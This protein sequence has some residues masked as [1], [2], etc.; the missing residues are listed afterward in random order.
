MPAWSSLFTL[1][2]ASAPQVLASCAYGT[3]L[4]PRAEAGAFEEPKF[5]YNGIKG[6]VNWYSLDAANAVCATGKNQS[7]INM[8]KGSF[9]LIPAS[10]LT[11]DIPDFTEGAEFE[12][13]GTTVEIIAEEAGGGSLELGETSYELKQFHFHLPSEHLDNGTSMAMEMHMVWQSA[14]EDIAVIGVYID[15]DD[16]ATAAASASAKIHHARGNKGK[17]E[18]RS[19]LEPR[20][21]AATPSTVLETVLG[22]VDKIAT[23]GATTHTEPLAMS[24]IVKLLTSGSFQSYAGSLTTPPCSEGVKWLVSNK[25]VS[26]ST[27]TYLKARS[28]IGFNARY[29]QNA[30]GEENLLQLAADAEDAHEGDD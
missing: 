10:E 23:P 7:P 21:S 29:P 8:A 30:P 14:E 9:N 18:K 5:G 3:H 16:G 27:S 17:M 28:V 19:A 12:N 26:I 22:S 24:E 15:L 6:P 13:L 20:Q 11:L 1:L 25:K 4:H 2:A